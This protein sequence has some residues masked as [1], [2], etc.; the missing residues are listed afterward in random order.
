MLRGQCRAH[1]LD[2]SFVLAGVTG[3]L[4]QSEKMMR[5]DG[6]LEALKP[7]PSI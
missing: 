1:L 5:Q 4:P 7:N 6:A 3:Y 2:G